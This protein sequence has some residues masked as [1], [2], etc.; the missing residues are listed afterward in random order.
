MR[1]REIFTMGIISAMGVAAV[2]AT[3]GAAAE[4]EVKIEGVEGHEGQLAIGLYN[5]AE[6]F[7]DEGKEFKGALAELSGTNVLYTFT[8]IPAG[9]YAVAAF[10]DENG[11]GKMDRN[12]IGLPKEG[13][14]FSRGAKG[15]FGPPS[16]EDAAVEVKEG[17]PTRTRVPLDY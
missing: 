10:H 8:D 3:L 16:F 6:G 12:L 2:C 11:D 5:G 9:T 14:G 15:K 13:F 17:E 7:P 4:L 1:A